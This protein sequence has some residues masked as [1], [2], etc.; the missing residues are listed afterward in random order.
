MGISI[1]ELLVALS[2]DV[3]KWWEGLIMFLPYILYCFY[4][5]LNPWIVEKMG[6]VRNSDVRD[7]LVEGQGVE[8]LALR[9]GGIWEKSPR[10]PESHIQCDPARNPNEYPPEE[11][12]EN[13]RPIPMTAVPMSEEVPED[14][15]LTP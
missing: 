14:V 1:A 9:Y 8:D 2:D 15:D 6:L 10:P 12:P 7:D 3:V 4:M 11:S 13:E 5:K